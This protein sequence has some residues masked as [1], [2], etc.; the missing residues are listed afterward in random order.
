MNSTL[1][2]EFCVLLPSPS[3]VLYA[4]IPF[5]R[6]NSVSD[7]AII[8]V[9]WDA[10][11]SGST[12]LLPR[13][14]R[15][16]RQLAHAAAALEAYHALRFWEAAAM[17]SGSGSVPSASLNFFC[18]FASYLCWM[19]RYQNSYCCTMMLVLFFVPPCCPW[20]WLDAFAAWWDFSIPWQ[21]HT[22]KLP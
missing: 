4:A 10:S 12:Y 2:Y 21:F 9:R 19:F 13:R 11:S 5:P 20:Y 7:A 8:Q 16:S 14:T 6:S 18:N 1:L 17:T 3:D 15:P 22:D